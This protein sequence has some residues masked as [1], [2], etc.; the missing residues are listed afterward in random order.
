MNG[1]ALRF[2]LRDGG[3]S[4]NNRLN[5]KNRSQ[6]NR[7]HNIKRSQKYIHHNVNLVHIFIEK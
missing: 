5:N 7:S 1:R 4:I 2:F 6:D 3:I